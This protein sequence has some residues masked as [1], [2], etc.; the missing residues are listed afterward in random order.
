[1]LDILANNLYILIKMEIGRQAR[2]RRKLSLYRYKYVYK[3]K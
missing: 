2:A 3:D 1:M